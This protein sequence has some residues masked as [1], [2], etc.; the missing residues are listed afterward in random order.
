MSVAKV[1]DLCLQDDI[2]ILCH[3]LLSKGSKGMA[4]MAARAIWR[5][6]IL[7]GLVN[8]PIQVFSATQRFL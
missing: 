3:L 6:S 4:A 2:N 1:A 7:F 8:I 5:G